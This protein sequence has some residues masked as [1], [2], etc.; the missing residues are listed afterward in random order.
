MIVRW[1]AVNNQETLR[2]SSAPCRV[3]TSSSKEICAGPGT[4]K[5]DGICSKDGLVPF[6]SLEPCLDFDCVPDIPGTTEMD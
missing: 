3:L 5:E 1:V 4:C 2:L 6:R